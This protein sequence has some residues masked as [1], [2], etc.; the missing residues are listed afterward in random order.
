MEQ[1]KEIGVGKYPSQVLC[2]RWNVYTSFP[3]GLRM[4]VHESVK[5]SYP[6]FYY[7]YEGRVLYR[8]NVK[9]KITGTRYNFDGL[10]TELQPSAVYI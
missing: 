4:Y 5:R 10:T 1:V 2:G 3:S 9:S 8:I 7:P 6:D